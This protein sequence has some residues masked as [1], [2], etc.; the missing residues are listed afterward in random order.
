MQYTCDE[1]TALVTEA[2]VSSESEDSSGSKKYIAVI[3][4]IATPQIYT[5]WEETHYD[6]NN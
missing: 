2:I 5:K 4:S 6:I 3:D 1:I